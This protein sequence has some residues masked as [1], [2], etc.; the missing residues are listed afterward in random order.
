MKLKSLN[1]DFLTESDVQKLSRANIQTTEQ[2]ITYADLDALS[3]LSTIPVKNLKL[4]KKYI[5]G[6]YAPFPQIGNEVLSKYVKNLF[7]IETGI[8]HL[9]ELISNGVYSNE[10]SEIQGSTSS[11]KTQ[12]CLNLIVNMLAK[13]SNYKCLYI[14]S[15]KNFCL[16]RMSHLLD[17]KLD[18]KACLKQ[19]KIIDCQ[20]VFHLIHVLS[21]ITKP[22]TTL[23]SKVSNCT[24]NDE[25]ALNPN[26]LIIDSL[27]NLFNMFKT[28]N[29]LDAQ[30]YLNYV[31]NCL[32]YLATNMNLMIVFTSNL[33][34]E[35]SYHSNS[36]FYESWKNMSNLILKLNKLDPKTNELKRTVEILKCNRPLILNTESKSSTCFNINDHGLN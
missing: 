24:L 16:K 36:I 22:N 1:C 20:N 2:L 29:Q 28:I 33:D 7:I 4:V 31:S 15:N 25:E 6:Q 14:D 9:D 34:N 32:K 19:I 5:I 12:F 18:S 13:Y 26:L 11:G 23:T 17:S 35:S 10:I 8:A 27:T 30:F 3:R 21:Q